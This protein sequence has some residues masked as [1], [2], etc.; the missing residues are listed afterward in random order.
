MLFWRRR[1]DPFPPPFP[2]VLVPSCGWYDSIHNPSAS[3]LPVRSIDRSQVKELQTTVKELQTTT[4]ELQTSHA[5]L[6]TSHATLQT[7][8]ASL[9]ASH[10]TLSASHTS[11]NTSHTKLST[12]HTSLSSSFS[13][14]SSSLSSLSDSHAVLSENHESLA[15][16]ISGVK[17]GQMALEMGL[18]NLTQLVRNLEGNVGVE[19][20]RTVVLMRKVES[21]GVG[22][23][24]GI[25]E[26]V[27]SAL[28]KIED[29]LAT[30]DYLIADASSGLAGKIA[31]ALN[32]ALAPAGV[33]GAAGDDGLTSLE[34]AFRASVMS[35]VEKKSGD[36][37]DKL[38]DL[39]EARCREAVVRVSD[40]TLGKMGKVLQ[41][42]RER[43][44]KMHDGLMSDLT[45][46]ERDFVQQIL[47]IFEPVL[48]RVERVAESSE[49]NLKRL[50]ETWSKKLA[51][52]TE[53]WTG[54]FTKVKQDLD[55]VKTVADDLVP[56]VITL[57]QD[58]ETL[59]GICENASS[60]CKAISPLIAQMDTANRVNKAILNSFQK[61]EATSTGLGL[62]SAA[63]PRQQNSNHATQLQQL[64][65]AST[66][67]S[68]TAPLAQPQPQSSA[69]ARA[70]LQHLSQAR[71]SSNPEL[72]QIGQQ[73]QLVPFV[74]YQS[75]SQLGLR[76]NSPANPNTAIASPLHPG[77]GVTMS[78]PNMANF[79]PGPSNAPTANTTFPQQHLSNSL[80]Q[81]SA[82]TT[83][84]GSPVLSGLGFGHG[85]GVPTSSPNPTNFGPGPSTAPAANT[86]FPQQHLPNSQEYGPQR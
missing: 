84:V 29:K 21:L 16:S 38:W 57:T 15:S 45:D 68:L 22:M 20:E 78:S 30:H 61:L 83:S 73:P 7:S 42:Y 4:K 31:S 24:I 14:L 77:P 10:T 17:D 64:P 80:R 25:G 69:A 86:A 34:K 46:Q 58:R 41:T 48:G 11:L 76:Q 19:R 44:S 63:T 59:R 12:D 74:P 85:V 6:Q 50:E 5:T 26:D 8:H 28:D 66:S 47:L 52:V 71:P 9:Q 27:K 32:L 67:N 62:F 18:G 40:G 79:G 82:P 65:Q 37:V 56:K 60:A 35:V 55:R 54:S 3:P 2:P 49:E 72:Q 33:A 36:V 75:Q 53:E 43:E 13:T 70:A 1:S 39:I 23:G 51:S 81:N